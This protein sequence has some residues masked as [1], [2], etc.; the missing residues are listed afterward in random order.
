MKDDFCRLERRIGETDEAEK[1]VPPQPAGPSNESMNNFYATVAAVHAAA[2]EAKEAATAANDA[3]NEATAMAINTNENAA[4]AAQNADAASGS[5]DKAIA[6]A[7]NMKEVAADVV[8]EI[9]RHASANK[10]TAR[11]APPQ[12][13]VSSRLPPLLPMLFPFADAHNDEDNDKEDH[14]NPLC[15]WHGQDNNS[16]DTYNRY[17]HDFD[18]KQYH[19]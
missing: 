4:A 1:E 11:E 17:T 9:R 16:M 13:A 7:I 8:F 5:A 19:H 12:P 6:A 10:P 15:F 3:A 18:I 14:D 2:T